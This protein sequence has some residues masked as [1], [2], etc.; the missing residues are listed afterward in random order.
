MLLPVFKEIS[1]SLIGWGFRRKT[2]GGDLCTPG[3]PVGL[4]GT[5][6]DKIDRQIM[7]LRV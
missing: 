3:G 5:E 6:R 2:G 1:L 7:S 4:D